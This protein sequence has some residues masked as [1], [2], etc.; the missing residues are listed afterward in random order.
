MDKSR[1]TAPR[2]WMQV[3]FSGVVSHTTEAVACKQTRTAQITTYMRYVCF[4][5]QVY[6]L[7][8]YTC[9][10]SSILC[11]ST[12]THI[13]STMGADSS[14][15]ESG[16]AGSI[17]AAAVF[18]PGQSMS[19]RCATANKA[20]PIASPMYAGIQTAR[21]LN[22]VLFLSTALQMRRLKSLCR[23]RDC[24]GRRSSP[25]IRISWTAVALKQG[26]AVSA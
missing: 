18:V 25:E 2:G 16:P 13:D 21:A 5:I 4:Q 20:A 9:L 22:F 15:Q 12:P 14:V 3:A 24:G 6:C 26:N 1:R 7:P 10:F 8:V 19:G 23:P 17:T 11:C